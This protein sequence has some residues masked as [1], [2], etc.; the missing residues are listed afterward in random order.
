M[1]KRYYFYLIE[2]DFYNLFKGDNLKAFLELFYRKEDSSFYEKQFSLFIKDIDNEKVNNLLIDKYNSRKDFVIEGNKYMLNNFITS[3][4][5]VL[6]LYH[7]YI[8][9]ETD[10]EVSPFIATLADNFPDL[11]AIDINNYKIER[12]GLV[13]LAKIS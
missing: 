3:N 2:D 10:Y 11:V 4:N 8:Y 5:E 1:M 12:V 13:S 7:N 9:V 6:R